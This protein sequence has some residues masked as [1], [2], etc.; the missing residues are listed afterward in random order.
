ATL[1]PGTHMITATYPGLPGLLASSSPT[2]QQVVREGTYHIVDLIPLRSLS[3][4][5]TAISENGLIAANSDEIDFNG[6]RVQLALRVDPNRNVDVGN[7]GGVASS[8]YAVN[9]TGA[10]AGSSLTTGNAA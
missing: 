3:S 9:D 6:N 1:G 10:V 4:A 7:L 8:A 2:V 5:A